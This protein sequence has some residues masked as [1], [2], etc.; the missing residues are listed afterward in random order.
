MGRPHQRE[1]RRGPLRVFA[2]D[3]HQVSLAEVVDLPQ[4]PQVEAVCA[5]CGEPLPRGSE[6]FCC[7]GCAAAYR[8]VG[9]LGLARYYRGR[10][11]NPQIRGPRPADNTAAEV[12][13]AAVAAADGT[14]LL[15]ALIDR[16]HCAACV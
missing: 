10:Q 15:E 13:A 1:S 16:L 12:L 4:A 2:A 7:S 8:L 11:L 9:E 3:R 5:H 14:I 6:R